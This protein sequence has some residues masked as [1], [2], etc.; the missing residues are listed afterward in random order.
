MCGA[1]IFRVL[2]VV[3]VAFAWTCPFVQAQEFRMDTE[4]FVEGEQEPV[5]KTLTIFADGIVYD[6]L[7]DDTKEMTM[8]DQTHSRIV[9]LDPER[10]VKAE[11]STDAILAFIAK[12]KARL[13][14]TQRRYLIG[15]GM[16]LDT[17]PNDW[18]KL[19]NDR[20]IYRAQGVRPK[21][22]SATLQYRQFADWYAR[23]NAMR[24]G[25]LPPFARLRLNAEL[26]ERGLIPQEVER[27]VVLK[28]GLTESKETLRSRHSTNW[29][30]SQ[31]DRKWIDRVG[32][33]LSVFQTVPF[34]QY[35]Q[36]TDTA[37][38]PDE[39]KK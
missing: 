21:E 28:R 31:T 4:I 23:L 9:L 33:Y 34:T 29:R 3:L 1:V 38:V 32:T 26:A 2:S 24:L 14:D 8:F 36:Q 18:I 16:E 17:E 20:V 30:L 7:L 19:S 22:S 13:D 11:L 6:F 25:N 5:A 39:N 15:A 37:N 35:V 27:T 10:K 12:M